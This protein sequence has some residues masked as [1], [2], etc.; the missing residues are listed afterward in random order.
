MS[1]EDPLL[2]HFDPQRARQPLLRAAA[3]GTVAAMAMSGMRQLNAG[4]GVVER[5]PPQ[6]V[7]EEQV[8]RLL[9]QV[10]AARREAVIELAHW[11]YGAAAGVVFGLLPLRVRRSRL[12]GPIYGLTLWGVFDLAVAPLLDLSYHHESRPREQTALLL[13]HALYGLIVRE[14]QP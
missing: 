11:G 6:A 10:P 9:R 4:L 5:T 1:T 3:R 7:L 8:P 2:Q 12:F 13:D 14:E